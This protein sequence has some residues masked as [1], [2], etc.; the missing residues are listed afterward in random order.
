MSEMTYETS[1]KAAEAWS[2][3]FHH[4]M[5]ANIALD[6]VQDVAGDRVKVL[7]AILLHAV[8][9]L[10][11]ARPT[12]RDASPDHHMSAGRLSGY[13]LKCEFAKA[14]AERDRIAR[15]A[16]YQQIRTVDA[17]ESAELDLWFDWCKT[18]ELV[19]TLCRSL[20]AEARPPGAKP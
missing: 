4:A 8:T 18:A 14:W 2:L 9:C 16:A 1:Y 11:D 13:I 17:R 12:T 6:F 5:P 20:A 10:A 15:N 3:M 19:L 7:D